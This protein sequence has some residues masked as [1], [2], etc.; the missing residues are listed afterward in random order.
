MPAK[1]FAPAWDPPLYYGQALSF[2]GSLGQTPKALGASFFDGIGCFWLLLAVM[3]MSVETSLSWEIDETALAVLSHRHPRVEHMGS[4]KDFVPA[5]FEARLRRKRP[6][7]VVVG[8]GSPCTQLS[9]AGRWW[10]GLNGASSSLFWDFV[11][12]WHHICHICHWLELPVLLWY[13]N[14]VPKDTAWV[15]QMTESLK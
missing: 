8:A 12:A 9:G 13:E 6:D 15:P 1:G 2:I 5:D 3:S 4:V 14:V 7:L 10:E 11:Q